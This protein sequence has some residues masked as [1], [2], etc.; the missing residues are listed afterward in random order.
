MVYCI[1]NFANMRLKASFTEVHYRGNFIGYEVITRIIVSFNSS[2]KDIS[3]FD[4][5]E[6]IV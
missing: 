3:V 5:N 6:V 4:V 2:I 1:H